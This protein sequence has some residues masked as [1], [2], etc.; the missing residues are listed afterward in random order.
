MQNKYFGDIHDFYK[1]YLLKHISGYFSIGINWCLVKDE[2]SK[3]GNKKLRKKEENKDKILFSVLND[4]KNV[5]G[6]KK[7]FPKKVSYF[8]NIHEQ[9]FLNSLYQKSA[10]DKLN[11]KD[12]I[13]FD[14]DNGLEVLTTDNKKRYKYLSYD[15]LEKYWANGNSM[16][17]YQHLSRDKSALENIIK[18]IEELLKCSKYG[19]IEII[20][21]GNVAYIFIIQKRHFLLHDIIADFINKNIEYKIN[22]I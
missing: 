17:V 13:F 7:Y 1:Y 2:N 11:K 8:D 10:F 14:P 15:I 18:K 6:I 5:N 12:I 22:E 4:S 9:Y 3:D 19:N 20:K 21:K 16:I